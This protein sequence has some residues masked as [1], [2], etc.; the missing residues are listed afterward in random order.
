MARLNSHEVRVFALGGL[1]E[2]G[3]NLYCI[4]YM[5][6]IIIIDC[7]ILFPDEHL[8]GVDYVIPNFSYLKENEDKI[9]GL[10]VTHGHEDHIGGIPFLLKEVKIPKI[11][12]A[13]V[14]VALIKN[15]LE[16]HKDIRVPEIVE[17]TSNDDFA[18]RPSD[19]PLFTKCSSAA[20]SLFPNAFF[21][22]L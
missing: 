3:K 12:A 10:F 16:E 14:T 2:V 17:F 19:I 15:K 22:S 6:Q 4:E 13:G 21:K 11:Y 1:L 18:W 20:T 7:G 8:L 5:N 9:I